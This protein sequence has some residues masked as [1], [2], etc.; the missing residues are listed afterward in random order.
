VNDPLPPQQFQALK[1][2]VGK[3]PDE[4]DA[5]A[6][7]VILLDQLVQVYPSERKHSITSHL[8]IETS[9]STLQD[10]DLQ[11]SGP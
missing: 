1:Q 7:E 2:G 10:I 5:E 8:G 9:S 3:A 6:L 4:G 11:K